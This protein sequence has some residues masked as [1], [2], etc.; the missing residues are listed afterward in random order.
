M[1][2]LDGYR[3]IAVLAEGPAFRLV[4]AERD[5]GATV[6]VK[7]AI[8]RRSH[9]DAAATLQREFELERRLHHPAVVEPLDFIDD[10]HQP[11]LVLADDGGRTLRDVLGD[12]PLSLR[13]TLAISAGIASGLAELHRHDIV[14]RD[15]QPDRVMVGSGGTPIRIIDLAMA[16]VVPR[17]QAALLSPG[18]MLGSLRYISPE[19]TG[20]TSRPVDYRTDLYSLGI[21][22][23]EMLT[24][25]TPFTS[26][27]RLDLVHDHLAVRAPRVSNLRDEIPQIVADLVARLLE[28][29]PGD[30]YRSALGV[31][32]DLDRIQDR[33]VR[34]LGLDDTELKGTAISTRFQMPDQL[35]GRSADVAEL[36]T[37]LHRSARGRTSLLF[38]RGPS[39]VGKTSLVEELREPVNQLRGYVATGKADQTY[40]GPAHEVVAAACRDLVRQLLTEDDARINALRSDL[41]RILGTNA[42][43]L[44][45]V[46]P[47]LG[48]LLG[49]SPLSEPAELG[50]GNQFNALASEVV[51]AIASPDHPVVLVLDDLQWADASTVEF[52]ERTATESPDHALLL[53]AAYRDD[54]IDA[55][56]P[57]LVTQQRF[58]ADGVAYGDVA[59]GPLTDEAVAEFVAAS[60][61][62]TV[63]DATPLTDLCLR[64][65]GGNPLSIRLFLG[66]LYEDGLLQLDPASGAWTWDVDQVAALLATTHP[67]ELATEKLDGLSEGAR[68]LLAVM[69]IAGPQGDVDLL[70]DIGISQPLPALQELAAQDLA[71]LTE[72]PPRLRWE[73]AH[74]RIRDAAIQLIDEPGRRDWHL[75]IGAALKR[76]LTTLRSETSV[77]SVLRHLNAAHQP[78]GPPNADLALMNLDGGRSAMRT[79]D[80]AA[81]LGYY[82]TGAAILGPTQWEDHPKA[83]FDLHLGAANAARL[84]ADFEEMDRWVQA[85]ATAT[86]EPDQLVEAAL[87]EILYLNHKG[88][89]LE[90]VATARRALANLGWSLPESPGRWEV[91]RRL[92]RTRVRL[93]LM[94]LGS[95]RLLGSRI[96]QSTYDTTALSEQH[97]WQPPT[98]YVASDSVLGLLELHQMVDGTARSMIRLLNEALG[99]AYWTNRRVLTV[100]IL[101][102]IDLTAEYGNHPASALFYA[103]YGAIVTTVNKDPETGLAFADVGVRMARTVG[104]LTKPSRVRLT[105]DALVAPAKVPLREIEPSLDRAYTRGIDSGDVAF[106]TSALLFA[107]LHRFARGVPL[108][109]LEAELET[110]EAQLRRYS[111]TRNLEAARALHQLI[112]DLQHREAQLEAFSGPHFAGGGNHHGEG[113]AGAGMTAC[114]VSTL[115]AISRWHAGDVTGARTDIDNAGAQLDA[116][117]GQVLVPLLHLY[118][119]LAWARPRKRIHL[120]T[121]RR[122]RGHR[123]R[124]AW[125]AKHNPT[126][127]KQWLL[128]AD[129][130]MAAGR[131][132]SLRALRLLRAAAELALERSDPMTAAVAELLSAEIEALRGDDDATAHHRTAAGDAYALWGAHALDERK[133]DG[134]EA[135]AAAGAEDEDLDL[136]T[137]VRA[138]EA[139]S[140]QIELDSLLR[141][142]LEVVLQSAGAERGV[143]YRID[144]ERAVPEAEGHV[145]EGS[146]EVSVTTLE[147]DE[148][149]DVAASV[150]RL[151]ARTS[152]PVLIARAADDPLLRNDD[153]L[154]ARGVRSLFCLPLVTQGRLGGILYLENSQVDGA[155]TTARLRLL[156]MLS[157]QAASALEKARLHGEQRQLIEAQDRF[158]PAQFLRTLGHANLIDVERGQGTTKIVDVLFTDIRSFTTIVETMTPSEAM[159]F[160]ND[161]LAHMEPVVHEYGGFI[162]TYD[163]DSILALFDAGLDGGVLSAVAMARAERLDN[164]RRRSVRLRPVR[165]GFGINSAAVMMGIVGGVNALRATIIG[166]AVNVASRIESLTKRYATSMLISENTAVRLRPETKATLRPLERVQLV[167]KTQA[168]QVFEVLEA[169]DAD[170]YRRRLA[171]LDDHN[172]AIVAYERGEL[173]AARRLF[174]H[175]LEADPTDAPAAVMLA[176]TD[177]LIA[178]PDTLELPPIT[179]LE[180]K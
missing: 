160:V 95:G 172:E 107:S 60:V 80:Y 155:F 6:L 23:Y 130:A 57:V 47:E 117:L 91:L 96:T 12:G 116:I 4:R 165:T 178:S 139:I 177:E 112:Y 144:E 110:T 70:S 21:T 163:G 14:H 19:Q 66:T 169:L 11:A 25:D 77:F 1:L 111:Q 90:A 42:P 16:T 105:R 63:A 134:E 113:V 37:W 22:M 99:S 69:A 55:A 175:V 153:S 10:G 17:Q 173:A 54:E 127:Y 115:R 13:E 38:V 142:L 137:V 86:A 168:L 61:G 83:A 41:R 102:G 152:E 164:E 5:G 124:L 87:L 109:Q 71:Q 20:R 100:M 162:D 72:D 84:M 73:I 128:L 129:G 49:S 98:A 131:G 18:V 53:V 30:R 147:P 43:I 106:G 161:Y 118:G 121:A 149:P 143:L 157:S 108:D 180:S 62:R 101:K 29:D 159:A 46:V 122:A 141:S 34:G 74:D 9:S 140:E 15:L 33:L 176:R 85:I 48:V 59:L 125:Y 120:N 171:T 150:V 88:Q 145:P 24:G 167:G 97:S 52:I 166:D 151:V 93:A 44:T 50:K 45:E 68:S 56:H 154:R 123:R 82:S 136:A 126:Q 36:E 114:W 32:Q 40:E 138:S 94:S 156:R 27:D 67:V 132:R 148:Q 119:V 26:S 103:F 174:N 89:H 51:A 135:G 92:R 8:R 78:G 133:T 158:V 179:R 76:R 39:G 28:K 81:A 65:T 31:V 2:A 7:T 79:T 35:F 64:G 146:S 3:E 58:L 104:T 75:R 170:T